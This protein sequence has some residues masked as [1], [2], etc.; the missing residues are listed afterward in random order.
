MQFVPPNINSLAG[1]KIRLLLS[2][3]ESNILPAVFLTA[4]LTPGKVTL[5]SRLMASTEAKT[6][7]GVEFYYHSTSIL[8][9]PRL[10]GGVSNGLIEGEE[11]PI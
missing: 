6:V 11:R 9:K 3:T 1:R 7:H 10:V 2:L 8:S 5:W 4:R